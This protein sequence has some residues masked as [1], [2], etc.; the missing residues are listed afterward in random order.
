MS[1]FIVSLM[2]AIPLKS[3]GID[4]AKQ[5][6]GLN[7]VGIHVLAVQ[8][9]AMFGMNWNIVFIDGL[10]SE[11]GKPIGHVAIVD[12][13]TKQ[14]IEQSVRGKVE[15]GLSERY[16]SVVQDGKTFNDVTVTFLT[17]DADGEVIK[18][19]RA[20]NK[21]WDDKGEYLLGS[22]SVSGFEASVVMAVCASRSRAGTSSRI[23]QISLHWPQS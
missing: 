18:V 10:K 21:V 15:A 11:D 13:D 1:E 12:V 7:C 4:I 17:E 9:A 8:T 14:F 23:G 19:T 5:A 3:G 6:E 16:G 20:L 2:L 22:A